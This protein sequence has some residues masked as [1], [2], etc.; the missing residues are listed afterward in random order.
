[1]DS[2]A[3]VIS[4]Q[5]R[6]FVH[7]IELNRPDSLNALDA[8]LAQEL[9]AALAAAEADPHCRVV[10]LTGAGR[11]FC[12]GLDLTGYGDAPG[13]DQM[14]EVYRDLAF[15][16]FVATIIQRVHRLPKPV[17]AQ[18]NGPAA[19]FG[20]ALACASDLRLAAANAVFATSF[21]RIGATGCD[22]GLSWLLPRLVGAGR[23]HELMLTGR[24]FD[25]AEALRIGL[26]ADVV[27]PEQLDARVSD[28]LDSLL[29]A[30]P[31]SLELTKQGM[32]L[33]LEL[34]SLD[35][36]I[37]LENRQQILSARTA[38]SKEARQA[39][40]ERRAPAFRFH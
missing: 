37:E 35:A 6:P 3:A 19:G 20:L 10:V 15:Q 31:L 17:V 7:R 24:R 38:D 33:G 9:H 1:M 27:A 34:P 29:A 14:G 30:A 8:R 26:L 32:W 18:I 16:R 36:A 23:A 21:I 40:D 28:V 12:S 25:A 5:P 2:G 39:R 4:S 11:G 13:T 22:L